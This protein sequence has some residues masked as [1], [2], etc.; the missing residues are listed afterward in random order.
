LIGDEDMVLHQAVLFGGKLTLVNPSGTVCQIVDFG[1][2]NNVM[3]HRTQ[4]LDY[5]V[6]LE[7]EMLME[8]DDGSVTR[9]V[10]NDLAVERGTIYAC[11]NA[12]DTQWARMLFVLQEAAPLTI[13]GTAFAEDLGK[14]AHVKTW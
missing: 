11:R 7:G 4:S 13:N 3:M 1:P 9:M 10:R 14:G 12:S 2:K 6:V 8:L 5:G